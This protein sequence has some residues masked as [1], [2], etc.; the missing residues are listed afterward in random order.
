MGFILIGVAIAIVLTIIALKCYND[1]LGASVMALALIVFIVGLL[2]GLFIPTAFKPREEIEA[3]NLV[4]LSD[5][6]SVYGEKRLLF[7]S[8]NAT[9]AYTYYTQIESDFADEES[10]AYVSKTISGNNNVTIVEQENC[11]NPRLVTYYE[12]SKSTFWS[13]GIGAGRVYYVFYVPQGTVSH[14]LELG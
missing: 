8:I 9:N 13:F 4:N 7:V 14:N 10:K 5:E 6:V 11:I 3:V 12:K 2:S 1:K